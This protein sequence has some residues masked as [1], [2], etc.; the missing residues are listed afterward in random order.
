MPKNN[1]DPALKDYLSKETMSKSELEQH[2]T[3]IQTD[4]NQVYERFE[5]VDKRF[6]QVDKRFD[7]VDRRFDD[8][9]NRMD[10]GFKRLESICF[11]ILEIVREHDIKFSNFEKRLL[12]VE[13]KLA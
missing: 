1:F 12:S 8:L 2:F 6:E 4:F 5:Q 10:K 13:R 7:A 3:A 9:E 11:A